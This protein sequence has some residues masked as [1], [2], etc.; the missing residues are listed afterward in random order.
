[1]FRRGIVALALVGLLVALEASPA[2]ARHRKPKRT[3]RLSAKCLN[4]GVVAPDVP[5]GG[6]STFVIRP[7]DV[8]GNLLVP[9]T[10]TLPGPLPAPGVETTVFVTVPAGAFDFASP[11]EFPIFPTVPVQG[12]VTFTVNP[13]GTVS[14]FIDVFQQIGD[15]GIGIGLGFLNL[16]VT[17]TPGGPGTLRCGNAS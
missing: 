5:A 11:P 17:F 10:V 9:I 15:T 7:E 6:V 2:T 16:P 3:A 4:V 12:T 1:M 13:D 14:G 8:T